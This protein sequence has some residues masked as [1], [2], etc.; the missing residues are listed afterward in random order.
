MNT[1]SATTNDVE[2]TTSLQ[3]TYMNIDTT[4]HV[5][6]KLSKGQY[7]GI[8][9]G[10]AALLL[11]VVLLPAIIV[12]YR[13]RTKRN[14]LRRGSVLP[15]PKAIDRVDPN[16][17][18]TVDNHRITERTL[19]PPPG[20]SIEETA[21][22][23]TGRTLPHIPVLSF[24]E[25]ADKITGR[26]LPHIPVLSFEETADK[27]TGRTLPPIPVHSSVETA[28]NDTTTGKPTSDRY[29]PGSLQQMVQPPSPMPH[30]H[31][32]S[33]YR[34]T[35]PNSTKDNPEIDLLQ[36]HKPARK[37]ETSS[38]PLSEPL[39]PPAAHHTSKGYINTGKNSHEHN[40]DIVQDKAKKKDYVNLT[41][42]VNQS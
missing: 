40:P 20:P 4:E 9:V 11:L 21:D 42:W 5:T 3:T 30:T 2:E 24:E 34:N 6:Q 12:M 1:T 41:E 14:E 27:I 19:P 16:I 13:K 10:C 35:G 8:G 7:I 38:K 18:E 33:G 32:N 28:K 17:E 31:S 23:I 37:A 36:D 26:A 39:T 29:F 25:T 22:K 15:D